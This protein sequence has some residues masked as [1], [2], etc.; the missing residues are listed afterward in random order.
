MGAEILSSRDFMT[1]VA[2]T[3]PGEKKYGIGGRE[4]DAL[5]SPIYPKAASIVLRM[6]Y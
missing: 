4:A 1:A 3:P 2:P 6:H 5:F